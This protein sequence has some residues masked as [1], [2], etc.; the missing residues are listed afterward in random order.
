MSRRTVEVTPELL[1]RAYR[2]GLFPMAETRRG[3]RL[4]WLDPEHRGVLPLDRFHLPRRLLRTV[5]RGP[6]TVTADSDFRAVIAACAAAGT[7]PGGYLDQPR[8]RAPVRRA[9]PR[10]PGPQRRVPARGRA[11]RRA[12]RREPGRGVLRRE[13]VQHGARCVQGRAGAP[14]G[15]AAARRLPAARHAVRHQPPARNSARRRSRATATRRCSPPRWTKRPGGR[16]IARRSNR[17]S[18]MAVSRPVNAE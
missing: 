17:R 16:Q 14:G 11:G 13:H 2:V 1:L 4:Y 3:N 8:H 5:L 7:G 15:P 6:Y 12:V 10:G 9:A 18:G